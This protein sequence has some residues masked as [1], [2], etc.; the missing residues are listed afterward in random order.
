MIPDDTT[1]C[2]KG[3]H[4]IMDLFNKPEFK[5]GIVV[6]TISIGL[7]EQCFFLTYN[8]FG[9][10]DGIIPEIRMCK[11]YGDLHRHEKKILFG[12]ERIDELHNV[13]HGKYEQL[14]KK[15]QTLLRIP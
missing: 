7:K 4:Q 2:G 10:A 11:E 15:Y 1:S 8:N 5:F 6:L 14:T 12:E 13:F 9:S 3:Y